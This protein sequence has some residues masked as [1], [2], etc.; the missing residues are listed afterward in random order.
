VEDKF[1]RY[2]TPWLGVVRSKELLAE[3]SGLDQADDCAD[4]IRL[5]RP[6]SSGDADAARPGRSG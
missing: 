5:S 6:M 3:L 1:L 4:L 2:A